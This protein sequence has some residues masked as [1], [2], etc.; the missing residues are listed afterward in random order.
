MFVFAIDRRD[1]ASELSA[2]KALEREERMKCREMFRTC[3][4]GCGHPS[5][6]PRSRAAEQ[7]RARRTHLFPDTEA[8]CRLVGARGLV[9]EHRDLRHGRRWRRCRRARRRHQE[10]L[11]AARGQ[12]RAR[13]SRCRRDDERG[14]EVCG[15]TE[16]EELICRVLLGPDGSRRGA[17]DSRAISLFADRARTRRGTMKGCTR[18]DHPRA[19]PATCPLHTRACTIEGAP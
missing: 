1:Y 15:G 14:A 4:P 12:R 8:R 19:W 13:Q 17:V 6:T 16:S 11:R 18:R 2:C 7:G 5:D 3:E 10:A 9:Q